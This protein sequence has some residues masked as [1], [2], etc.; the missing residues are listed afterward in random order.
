[1]YDALQC[2]VDYGRQFDPHG[3][4]TVLPPF[5]EGIVS[6]GWLSRQKV[7]NEVLNYME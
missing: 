4:R 3:S 1:M 6:K 2:L 7:V 5:I